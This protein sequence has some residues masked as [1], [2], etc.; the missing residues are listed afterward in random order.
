[1]LDRLTEKWHEEQHLRFRNQ[2]TSPVCIFFLIPKEGWVCEVGRRWAGG[3]DGEGHRDRRNSQALLFFML[4]ASW[5][6]VIPD[7][8]YQNKSNSPFLPGPPWAE[9]NLTLPICKQAAPPGDEVQRFLQGNS[10]STLI[11]IKDRVAGDSRGRDFSMAISNVNLIIFWMYIWTIA[12]F[13]QDKK[14]KIELL[15]C[16]PV[17]WTYHGTRAP[18]LVNHAPTCHLPFLPRI[19]A[20]FHQAGAAT[21]S[22]LS[23]DQRAI[24]LPSGSTI[25]MLARKIQDQVLFHTRISQTLLVFFL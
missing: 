18:F 22:W 15:S 8:A 4:H 10:L 25:H 2:N 7:E 9:E 1:M 19:P 5:A 17:G 6:N 21:L 13:H 16:R 11:N 3:R 20:S 14:Q 24:H 12:I 23:G